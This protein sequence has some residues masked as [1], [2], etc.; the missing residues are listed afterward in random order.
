MTHRR[1]FF[2]L[3]ALKIG[4]LFIIQKSVPRTSATSSSS[5]R[6]GNA[7]WIVF[8]ANWTGHFRD[9]HPDSKPAA[10][11][12]F[13][14]SLQNWFYCRSVIW[15]FAKRSVGTTTT[16]W[17]DYVTLRATENLQHRSTWLLRCT[18]IEPGTSSSVIGAGWFVVRWHQYRCDVAFTPCY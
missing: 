4:H 14:K 12:T 16:T 6:R 1:L 7:P 9:F 15:Q 5:K 13:L 3:R 11:P 10:L 2:V 17:D 8:E 18:M